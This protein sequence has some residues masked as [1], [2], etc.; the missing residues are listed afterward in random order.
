MYRL[1]HRVHRYIDYAAVTFFLLAPGV[2]GFAGAA[3]PLAYALALVYL[4][5]ALATAYPDGGLWRLSFKLHGHV[6]LIVAAAAIASPWLFN[7][8][9]DVRARNF[10]V[11]AG[12]GSV[13]IWLMSDYRAASVAPTDRAGDRAM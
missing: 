1:D 10:F 5:L 13:L 6:E 7:F 9:N 11:V 4:A 12:A 8:G 2:F 3:A